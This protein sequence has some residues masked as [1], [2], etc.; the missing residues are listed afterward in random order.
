[1]ITAVLAKLQNG[2]PPHQWRPQGESTLATRSWLHHRGC[3]WHSWHL[4]CKPL[5]VETQ[6]SSVW[7]C[8]PSPESTARPTIHSHSWSNWETCVYTAR[9]PRN[10]F[11][12]DSG[13]G[14]L[15]HII[16]GCLELHFMCLS[17]MLDLLT[18]CF[19][20]QLQSGMRRLGGGGRIL[21]MIILS[22]QWS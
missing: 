7:Q 20:R 1:M 9:L 19:R 22:L 5:S 14:L 2:L 6:S 10:V 8:G 11:G 17:E 12:W 18:K 16:L 3:L 21:Y 4:N 13:F 15:S